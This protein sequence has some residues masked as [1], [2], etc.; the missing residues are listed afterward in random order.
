M[1]RRPPRSTLFPYTTLFR[2]SEQAIASIDALAAALQ[3]EGYFAD[4]RLATAVFLALRLQ[5]PLLLEGEPGV[6][7]T[8]LAQALAR[9]LA[10]RD[11]KSTRLNSSHQ[12]I[13]YA[14]F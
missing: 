7:K 9:V 5:R 8:A 14:V 1:I 11:R 3:A 10:R 13:S 6:G 2:S 4:R 12:I